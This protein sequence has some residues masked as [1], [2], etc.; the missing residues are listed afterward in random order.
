MQQKLPDREVVTVLRIFIGIR[1]AIAIVSALTIYQRQGPRLAFFETS[2][3]ITLVETSLLLAYL[4]LPGLRNRLGN[5][6]LPIGLAVATL[7]PIVE[8]M[9]LLQNFF[10]VA[11]L[12]PSPQPM[13]AVEIGQQVMVAGQFQL[14]IL[15]LVPLILVSWL[16]SF[17]S[18]LFY[19]LGVAL[20]DA[21]VPLL[22]AGATYFSVFRIA[23]EI[24][25]RSVIFVFLGFLI[26]RL[27]TEQKRQNSELAEANRR[28]ASYAN[29]LEQLT[30]SHE[31]NRLA[32]E[33]HDTLAHTLSAVA[34]Q[35]EGVSALQQTNPQKA[36]TMLEHSLMMTRD[37]LNETRRAIQA[38][39]AAPLEDL[40]LRTALE[41][42]ARSS[43]E[44]YGWELS[45]EL[46]EEINEIS[47]DAEH[48]IYR[49]VEEALRNAGQHAGARRLELSLT[50]SNG[51]VE[52]NLH[53]DGHGFEFDLEALD[54]RYGL[55][56]MLERAASIGAVLEIDSRPGQ[57]AHLRMLLE[58]AR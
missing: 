26:N 33:F 32:R 24:V 57:G 19:V 18:T 22:I 43:A 47:M 50:R 21:S 28:L 16:Y 20:L 25:M 8:N 2:T 17:R 55:R 15:L 52:L 30:V 51:R 39:R 29:T 38:L 48:C 9:F 42:L 23:G 5:W 40:G 11:I 44:R 46:P 13:V 6:H 49:I 7:G 37:G 34:V 4:W 10:Q 54:D 1:L 45:L 58:A 14:S 35:L 27:V 31:R 3:L 12:G 53:D 41:S 36:G 56:G